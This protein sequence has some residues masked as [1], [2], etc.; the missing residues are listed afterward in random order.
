[1]STR[2]RDKRWLV[3]GFGHPLES[4]E[5]LESGWGPAWASPGVLWVWSDTARVLPVSP[6][7]LLPPA[8]SLPCFPYN[9]SCF[10]Q[11]QRL[12]WEARCR[13]DS[14]HPPP[15]NAVTWAPLLL[16]SPAASSRAGF[17]LCAPPVPCAL[18]TLRLPP[19]GGDGQGKGLI[20]LGSPGSPG[21]TDQPRHP[22]RSAWSGNLA[23]YLCSAVASR[24]HSGCAPWPGPL[25]H[26]GCSTH[27]LKSRPMPQ[28]K[29]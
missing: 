27:S 22:R 9:E 29:W 14:A 12:R 28:R 18:S 13:E 4:P 17:A 25:G 1:M 8:P 19:G 7:Q 10:Q 21:V 3:Q 11:R 16:L 5:L 23:P 2:S 15:R 20:E 24:E 26:L 6:E